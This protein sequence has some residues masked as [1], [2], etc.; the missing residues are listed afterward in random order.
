MF[1]DKFTLSLVQLPD[2]SPTLFS[3]L[4]VTVWLIFQNFSISMICVTM[5]VMGKWSLLHC[6]GKKWQQKLQSSGGGGGILEGSIF[7]RQVQERMERM[8]QMLTRLFLKWSYGIFFCQEALQ[9]Q[10]WGEQCLSLGSICSVRTNQR[11]EGAVPR[12]T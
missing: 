5:E 2:T 9:S 1:S 3:H 11:E 10:L 4:K 8:L 12:G 6:W 7:P